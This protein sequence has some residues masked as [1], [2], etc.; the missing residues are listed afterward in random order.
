MDIISKINKYLVEKLNHLVS[1]FSKDGKTFYLW[2][3]SSG[4]YD[5]ELT[6][7]QSSK[8]IET[9]RKNLEQFKEE[10]VNLGYKEEELE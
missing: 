9:S 10:L 5:Y 2:Q 3:V 7:G 6:Q 8:V 1:K 4:G